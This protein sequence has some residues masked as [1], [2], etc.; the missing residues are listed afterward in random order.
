MQPWPRGWNETDRPEMI[1]IEK[2]A[3]SILWTIEQWPE[4]W[5]KGSVG[6]LVFHS[7]RAINTTGGFEHACFS[8]IDICSIHFISWTIQLISLVRTRPPDRDAEQK[9]CMWIRVQQR[10]PNE[11]W[12][13][14]RKLRFS[15]GKMLPRLLSG[16]F[17]FFFYSN[18]KR[19]AMANAWINEE[20]DSKQNRKRRIDHDNDY[21]YQIVRVVTISNCLIG[22]NFVYSYSLCANVQTLPL[23]HKY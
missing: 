13:W 5:E 6:W 16:F 10:W 11:L 12:K 7:I 4:E 18:F 17:S 9:L 8:R 19:Q 21:W 2:K 1:G 23:N 14:K 15:V 20:N 3:V 22:V